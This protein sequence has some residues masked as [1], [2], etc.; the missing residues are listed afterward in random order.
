ME[1]CSLWQGS[2]QTERTEAIMVFK[3]RRAAAIIFFILLSPG[4]LYAR[5]HHFSFY[6]DEPRIFLNVIEHYR[7]SQP[8]V[9]KKD[10]GLVRAGIIT[11]HFLASWMIV[12]FFE[13]LALQAAPERIILIGPDHFDKGIQ[14]ITVSSFPWK[15]PFGELR[16]D[17]RVVAMIKSL[18]ALSDDV[19]AFSGEHSIGI[20]VPFIHYYF[21]RSLIVPIIIQKHISQYALFA[22]TG[23]IEQLLD[24]PK[25]LVL[26]SMDFSHYQTSDEADRRDDM[27]KRTILSLNYKDVERLDVDCR[28]GLSILLSALSTTEG[29]AVNFRH[30]TNSGKI[31]VKKS[32]SVTS[33]FTVFFTQVRQERISDL[34]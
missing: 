32:H 17:E 22:L 12:D 6:S 5:S 31:A 2:E 30:H 14:P 27:S 34:R 3:I 7:S 23:I 29:V 21:P 13:C 16:A 18:L 24:D 11:H 4:L 25:T 9:C 20:I 15:T 10:G 33:Y 19:E 8:E 28:T 1:S 26:L